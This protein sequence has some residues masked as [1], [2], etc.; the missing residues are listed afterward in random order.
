MKRARSFFPVLVL[1]MTAGP[2]AADV[3]ARIGLAV[4]L[5]GSQAWGGAEMKVVPR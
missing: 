5:T 3:E 2:S 4:P 1:A